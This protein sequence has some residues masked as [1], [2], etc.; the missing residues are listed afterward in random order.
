MQISV[1]LACFS[2]LRAEQY[3]LQYG[4]LKSFPCSHSRD[5]C[6]S[7]LVEGSRLQAPS[8]SDS[9]CSPLCMASPPAKRQRTSK[10]VFSDD[11]EEPETSSQGPPPRRISRS[12]AARTSDVTA[13][14][15][16]T[17]STGSKSKSKPST[18]AAPATPKKAAVK[19][20]SASPVKAKKSPRRKK[21]EENSRSLHAFFGRASEEQRW[22]R[23]ADIPS[24]E[25][26]DV[27]NGDA[28]E[29][30]DSLDEALSQLAE[31]QE[32]VKFQLDRRKDPL[33]VAS[34]SSRTVRSGL[35]ASSHKFVKP[36][37]P[38]INKNGMNVEPDDN[39][40][41]RLHRPWADRYGPANLEELAVHKKKVADVHK[42]LGEVL[43][44]RDPRVCANEKHHSIR[45]CSD[46]AIEDTCSERPRGK[47]QNHCCIAT[48]CNIKFYSLALV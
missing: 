20:A 30:D 24:A 9:V 47:R 48:F 23:S 3:P 37:L 28:I 42:W 29:D 15:K 40:N 25:V 44:G 14:P 27:E 7:R 22:N 17:K 34:N 41:Q 21:T 38:S 46:W 4:Y 11:E 45:F 8:F 31:G 33:T 19:T 16:T 6:G 13:P 2:S 39:S 36:P 10:V 1:N 18:D 12:I 26:D 43:N 5:S 32:D 35:L